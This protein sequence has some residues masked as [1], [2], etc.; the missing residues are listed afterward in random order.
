VTS[1]IITA[2]ILPTAVDQQPEHERGF[3]NEREPPDVERVSRDH[4]R[5]ESV[6]QVS[7][8]GDQEQEAEDFRHEIGSVRQEA[9]NT[10]GCIPRPGL[11][12]P[13][14]DDGVVVLD[15][16]GSCRAAQTVGPG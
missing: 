5:T 8:A 15:T 7:E 6:H 16:E 9:S 14:Y 11:R 2:E 10:H 3:A 12:F 4:H 13:T 1:V